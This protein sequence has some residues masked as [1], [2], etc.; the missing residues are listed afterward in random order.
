MKQGWISKFITLLEKHKPSPRLRGDLDKMLDK[1]VVIKLLRLKES[2][3][4]T[5]EVKSLVR[6]V[7]KQNLNES[8]IKILN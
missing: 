5:R 7:S 8:P 1:R 4:E 2:D 3:F 6:D